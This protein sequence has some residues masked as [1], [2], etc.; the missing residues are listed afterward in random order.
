MV[1]Q[2][3][4]ERSFDENIKFALDVEFDI[5]SNGGVGQ[6]ELLEVSN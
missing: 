4:A 1:G 5:L 6:E 3:P 2:Y